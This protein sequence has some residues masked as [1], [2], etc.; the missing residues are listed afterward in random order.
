MEQRPYYI[1]IETGEIHSDPTISEWEFQIEATEDDVEQLRRLMEKIDNDSF[2]TFWRAHVPYPYHQDEENH[3][4]E[5]T[6][7]RI[8][9]MIYD[10]G[11]EKAKA[12][13]ESIGILK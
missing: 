11:D 12:F 3:Q 13:I 2:H 1:K 8:Y 7:A 10:H 9:R 6:L 5:D 4:Y